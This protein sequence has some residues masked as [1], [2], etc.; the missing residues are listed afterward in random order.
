L[1]GAWV[2]LRVMLED[3]RNVFAV[4][5]ARY[6][7]QIKVK[8]RDHAK[9]RVEFRPLA[10]ILNGRYGFLLFADQARQLLLGHVAPQTCGLDEGTE[11]AW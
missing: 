8:D 1:S 2:F 11:L 10:A 9:Q 6:D 3:I 4:L 5:A 7:L